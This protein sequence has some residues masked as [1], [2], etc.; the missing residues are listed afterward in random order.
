MAILA[1]AT[2]TYCFDKEFL[3]LLL[4]RRK[5]IYSL[6]IGG[7]RPTYMVTIT[8]T[9]GRQAF[10]FSNSLHFFPACLQPGLP[11]CIFEYHK[12]KFCYISKTS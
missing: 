10:L 1:Q 9:P 12:S 5:P 3:Y 2:A 6:K 11:D 8:L 7:V 4:L